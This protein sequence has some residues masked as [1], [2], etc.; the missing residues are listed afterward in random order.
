M[1][2]NKKKKFF[3][4]YYY[5]LLLN[6]LRISVVFFFLIRKKFFYLLSEKLTSIQWHVYVCG[7]VN[8]RRREK[9]NANFFL[10]QYYRH[11]LDYI[12]CFHVNDLLHLE[13]ARKRNKRRASRKRTFFLSMIVAFW[14]ND[15]NVSKYNLNIHDDN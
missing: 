10:H 12:A 14:F 6:Y 11:R 9:K 13:N 3:S 5:Y 1:F 8:K 2:N 7:E 4:F 15:V